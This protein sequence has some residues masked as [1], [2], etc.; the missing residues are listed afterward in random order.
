MPGIA[1]A[2]R[3]ATHIGDGLKQLAA[4]T[5]DLPVGA[6]LLLSDGGENTSGMGGSG[7]SPDALQALRNRRLPVHTVGFGKEEPAHD[8]EIEDVSVAASA[9]ANAR[10]AATVSLDA[11]RLYAARK[12]RSP[13][14]TET[15][16]S[17]KREITLAPGWTH[18][19]GDRSIFPSALRAQ[20]ACSL[21]SR[22]CRAKRIRNNAVTRPILVSDAKRR[23]LYVEGEPRWEYKFIRRAED[24]DPTVQVVS[25]LRTS[26]NK[27]YRQ[28]ISDP[29][30]L[31]DGFPVAP[32]D[33]FGY[34]GIIIGSVAAD[35]FHAAAAGADARVCR[36][37][38]RRHSVSGRPVGAERRRL[39]GIEPERSAAHFSARGNHNFH[40]NPATVN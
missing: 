16:R 4:D 38:R 27:I 5:A 23:I 32:E 28:G 11:A 12:Q 25:M 19:D 33:L 36:S 39:G 13:C 8:V 26:E 35:Y 40:R 9:A 3:S 37:P 2:G 10:V 6:I 24:D 1:S 31:A 7:I 22:L 20:K 30:E 29:N 14:V 17:P 15:R 18:P 21:A 34:S